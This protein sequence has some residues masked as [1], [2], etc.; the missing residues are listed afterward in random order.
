MGKYEKFGEE[1]NFFSWTKV[2]QF[3]EEIKIN[4]KKKDTPF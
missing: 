4:K 1:F 2:L 3:S